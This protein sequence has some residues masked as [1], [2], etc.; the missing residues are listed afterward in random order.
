MKLIVENSA[1]STKKMLMSYD[2]DIGFVCG[3]YSLIDKETLSYVPNGLWGAHNSLLPKYRGGSPLVWS[4]INGDALVG[5]SVFKISER[6]DA[7]DLLLQ[8]QVTNEIS[9]DIQSLINKIEDNLLAELP[10]KWSN[11]ING[12]ACLSSQAEE[13]ATYCGQRTEEDGLIDWKKPAVD[14]HNFIRA[15]SAPYPCAYTFLLDR[16]VL[17]L[18]SKPSHFI[19]DGTPGQILRRS[20][21]SIFVACGNRTAIEIL[22]VAINE[23][24][25]VPAAFIR[26]VKQR[27]LN[28]SLIK[29]SSGNE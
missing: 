14:I 6:M 21:N 4:I 29:G 11:L 19:Y 17:I 2:F 5:C 25:G 9:D 16:K 3:Y 7:G 20:A 13:N 10:K 12:E 22:E 23:K 24:L 26:S 15:Q 27:F 8:I 28:K 1:T 18:K